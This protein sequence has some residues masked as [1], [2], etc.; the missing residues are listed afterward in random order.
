MADDFPRTP[1]LQATG[2]GY[3]GLLGIKNGG[4]NPLQAANSLSPTIEMLAMYRASQRGP[5][6]NVGHNVSSIGG[7]NI[8]LF[9]PVYVNLIGGVTFV[10]DVT[11]ITDPTGAVATSAFIT[12]AYQ[13]SYLARL[14]G[15]LTNCLALGPTSGIPGTGGTGVARADKPFIMMPNDTLGIYVSAIALTAIG[16]SYYANGV[17]V[18][19]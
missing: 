6:G 4:S 14:G 11:I 5:L 13:P 2:A 17:E 19:S 16:F 12:V 3:L 1:L 7:A 10:E 18:R 9:V 8:N 15:S